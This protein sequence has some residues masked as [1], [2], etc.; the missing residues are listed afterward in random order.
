MPVTGQGQRVWSV[1]DRVNIVCSSNRNL[2][3][4]STK[5]VYSNIDHDLI[6]YVQCFNLP[7]LIQLKGWTNYIAPL[8][9]KYS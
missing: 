3:G 6:L 7:D 4:M 2:G 8:S 5:A 1:G 9:I